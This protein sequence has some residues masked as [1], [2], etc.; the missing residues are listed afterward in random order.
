MDRSLRSTKAKVNALFSVHA[1]VTGV[2]GALAVTLPHVAEWC[3][4]HHGETLALRENMDSAQKV[5]HVVIRLLGALLLASAW[6]TWFARRSSDAH[7]RR[8]LVQSHWAVFTLASLVLLRAQVTPGGAM[9][10][11]NWLTILAF[12]ALA[13][14]YAWF[15]FVERL[16]VFESLDKVAL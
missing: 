9:A 14:F 11:T 5:T 7:T 15:A 10:A 4:I 16:R 2:F 8:A 3:L 13:L 1:A 6:L 12:M